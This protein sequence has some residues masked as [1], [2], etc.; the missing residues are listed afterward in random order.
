MFGTSINRKI[1]FVQLKDT[2]A[3]LMTYSPEGW[4][5]AC[6]WWLGAG[7]WWLVAGD[8]D[9]WLVVDVWWLLTGGWWLVTGDMWLVAILLQN[10]MFLP[11]EDTQKLHIYWQT[12]FIK[13]S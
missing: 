3:K 2:S 10:N 8:C 9:L 6:G 7:G 11:E 1:S 4:L 13:Y 12:I 5:V